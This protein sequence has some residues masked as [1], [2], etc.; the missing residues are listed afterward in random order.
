MLAILWLSGGTLWGQK[1]S[2]RLALIGQLDY[3]Q[4]VND[5]WAYVDSSGHEYALLGTS[6][7]PA[8]I[9]LGNPAQPE[10]LFFYLGPDVLW[11]DLKTYGPYAYV[12]NEFGGGI[13]IIDLRF[14]PD[15]APTKAVVLQGVQTAHNLWV[16]EK[17]YLYVV[18]MDQFEGGIMILDLRNDPWNPTFVGSYSEAYVHDIYVRGDTAYAAE[19]GRG[20]TLI[21]LRDRS[22]PVSINSHLYPASLTHNT[23]LNQDGTVCFTTDERDDGFII[24]WDVTDPSDVRELDRIK[25]QLSNGL[26]APH[27]VH[28]FNDYLVVSHYTDGVWIFDASRPDHLVTVGYY[29]T[30]PRINGGFDGCWGAYPFLPSG[31]L[32]ASDQ[33]QGLFVLRPDFRRAAFWDVVVQDADGGFPLSGV[34]VQIL[35]QEE[36]FTNHQGYYSL[37]VIDSGEV[38]IRVSLTGYRSDTVLVQ[39]MPGQTLRD[40]LA[41]QSYPRGTLRLTLLDEGNQSPLSEVQ[42][43]SEV[44]SGGEVVEYT[45]VTDSVGQLEVS[46]VLAGD[47]QFLLGKWGYEQSE[48]S[49]SLPANQTSNLIFELPQ[50]YEDDFVLDLGWEVLSTQP[51][52]AWTRNVPGGTFL[53]LGFIYG[54]NPNQ[55]ASGDRGEACFFTGA[56]LPFESPERN[57]LDAGFTR[58]TSPEIDLAKFKQPL[59]SLQYWLTNL[60]LDG[61]AFTKGAGSLKIR[62]WYQGLSFDLL[63]LDTVLTNGWIS[64]D[65][66]PLLNFRDTIQ[67]EFLVEA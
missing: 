54:I 10:E 64:L 31:Y 46:G 9:D 44:V 39:L 41:L 66:I 13:Q 55:D 61:T 8:I 48:R 16:D 28:V 62:Q 42:V 18:G 20:L 25:A 4:T 26:A 23:W 36:G 12:S 22:A 45:W 24:A 51:T 5:V 17:G 19:L 43:L 14:L 21:D 6:I 47:H 60:R 37:G 35:G 40:T 52:G 53:N 49:A 11:R 29:D 63:T 1:D 32:L 7:G 50:T 27:N 30:S 33:D 2:L 58:L 67:L 38:A 34:K 56:G 57:D 65:S 15:S 3:G 59:L